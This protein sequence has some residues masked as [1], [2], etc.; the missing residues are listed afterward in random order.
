MVK[1]QMYEQ[2]EK[3]VAM[4]EKSLCTFS[5]VVSIILLHRYYIFSSN[6]KIVGGYC[7]VMFILCHKATAFLNVFPYK[8][9]FVV[10]SN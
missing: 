2:K 10:F 8:K 6:G 7:R 4:S 3:R 5:V 9:K 1:I